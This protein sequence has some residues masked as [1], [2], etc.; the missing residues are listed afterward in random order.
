MPTYVWS[1]A[2]CGNPN[3]PAAS[4]CAVCDC[5]AIATSG[6]IAQYRNRFR[7]SG[8][9]VLPAA[10]DLGERAPGSIGATEVLLDPMFML[11]FGFA[12]STLKRR[13]SAHA[14]KATEPRARG[15]QN[16]A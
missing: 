6:Q 1:C 2:A 4:R 16:D 5:P 10:A 15:G 11:L 7:D 8:G 14:R 3:A 12:P 13:G 9:D